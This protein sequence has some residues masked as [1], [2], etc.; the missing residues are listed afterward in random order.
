MNVN[1]AS[2]V[3]AHL[4]DDERCALRWR[5]SGGGIEHRCAAEGEHRRHVCGCGEW[6]QVER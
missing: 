4:V 5:L 6:V 2:D 3:A 1:G